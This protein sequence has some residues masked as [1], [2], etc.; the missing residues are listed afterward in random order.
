M[1]TPNDMPKKSC[2]SVVRDAPSVDHVEESLRTSPKTWLNIQGQ[3]EKLRER[4]LPISELEEKQL[5]GLLTSQNYYRLSGYFKQCYLPNQERFLPDFTVSR[6][7]EVY[8]L[9]NELREHLYTGLREIELLLRTQIA[10]SFGKKEPSGVAYLRRESYLPRQNHRREISPEGNITTKWQKTYDF[11]ANTHASLMS[12]IESILKKEMP[13]PFIKH[14]LDV[15]EEVPLWVMV[16][17]L[18]FGDL[19]KLLDTWEDEQD[20]VR[21]AS[22]LQFST[23][24]ELRVAVGNL[25][26]LRNIVAHHGRLWGRVFTRS[27]A[28]P[29]ATKKEKKGGYDPFVGMNDGAPIQIVT[30]ASKWVDLIRENN[31]FSLATTE[32]INRSDFYREGIMAYR[33]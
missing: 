22:R 23:S 3:I 9:D 6:L 25:N 28:F 32:I 8:S 1:P 2:H 7:I 13:E 11:W 30:L 4:G 17:A 33:F 19:S 15:G 24:K 16:E 31:D 10:Y 29:P 12:H 26:Y 14:Y 21:L 27:V 20:L 18:S 5:R